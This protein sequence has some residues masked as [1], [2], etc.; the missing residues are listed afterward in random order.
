MSFLVSATRTLPVSDA[1]AFDKLADH[2]AWPRFMPESFKVV[3]RTVGSLR[4]GSTF[5][6]R[7]MNG[8]V[9]FRLRVDV[10]RRP[11]ELTWS[12][13][14]PGVLRGYHRFLFVPK[15]ASEVEVRSEETWSGLLAPLFRRAIERDAERVG[16]E[17]LEGLARGVV[18]S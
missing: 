6:V 13:G 11:G 5:R 7:I 16:R 1:V 17:Q 9:P 15:S 4:E 18:Q 10:A 3:G 14:I 2:D 8:P 12:G